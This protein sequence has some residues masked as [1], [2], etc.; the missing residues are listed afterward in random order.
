MKS[1]RVSCAE[2]CWPLAGVQVR[3][4]SARGDVLGSTE[5][6]SDGR[7][8]LEPGD[9]LEFNLPGYGS[10]RY[11]RDQVPEHVRLLGDRPLGYG[12]RLSLDPG[13]DATLHLHTTTPC[14][15]TLRRHGA[16]LSVVDR[17]ALAEPSPQVVPDAPFVAEG[18]DWKPVLRYSAPNE[19][20]LYS[21]LLESEGHPA[22]A[23]PLVVSSG[24]RRR[25][26]VLVL[27]ST[28]TWL[29]YNPFGGR[30][31]Y[32]NYEGDVPPPPT[33]REPAWTPRDLIPGGWRKWLR[34]FLP[35]E[36]ELDD[37]WRFGKLSIHRP[38]LN[39]GLESD[40]LM[41]PFENHLAAGEWRV[42]AWLEKQGIPYDL[43]SQAELEQRPKVLDGYRVVVLSTHSEYWSRAMYQVLLQ[44]HD[45]GAW[46]CCL[47]ANS[48]FREIELFPD[49]SIRCVSMV[50]AQS[51]ANEGKL[52]GVRLGG[53][54]RAAGYEITAPNHWIYGEATYPGQTSFGNSSLNQP[55]P[56]GPGHEYGGS[57]GIL[58]GQ[59]AAGW[60][61][62]C[63]QPETPADFTVVARGKS[64]YAGAEIVV[65]EPQGTRGGVLSVGSIT[66]GGSLL[67]DPTS[68]G[69]VRNFLRS[70][71][72]S[73]WRCEE[74]VWPGPG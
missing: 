8:R 45:Q 14:R 17:R 10:K 40:E 41:A 69:M 30:S 48:I 55:L 39:S 43:I 1:G 4:L 26:D 35:A 63:T 9:E 18:L 62:D 37:P 68:S 70:A 2:L 44:A 38:F 71:L 5:T 52:L 57:A 53:M 59:G 58:N 60:E 19:P 36:R 31:R 7:W 49:G 47:G 25:S 42:L 72:G 74:P 24:S 33:P 22:Y 6:N 54:G 28:T 21:W 20:G 29:A 61:I 12:D 50:F 67:I 27:A 16:E 13:Q 64:W 3:S 56:R 15:L 65:R 11:P 32:R 23:L 46:I 34:R 51:C 66:F 73:A